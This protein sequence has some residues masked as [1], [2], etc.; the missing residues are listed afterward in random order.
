MGVPTGPPGTTPPIFPTCSPG[1]IVMTP[2][3]LKV[4]GTPTPVVG[5]V[6]IGGRAVNNTPR[7]EGKV[8]SVTAGSI[9]GGTSNTTSDLTPTPGVKTGT[10]GVGSL[11]VTL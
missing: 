1:S 9:V 11:I 7:H 3:H 8:L 6:T 4:H 2:F 5:L 10:V